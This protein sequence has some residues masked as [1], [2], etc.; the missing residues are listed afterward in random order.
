VGG[1]VRGGLLWEV[2]VWFW[3]LGLGWDGLRFGLAT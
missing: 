1:W 3:S 2:I